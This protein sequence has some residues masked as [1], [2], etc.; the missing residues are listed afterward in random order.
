MVVINCFYIRER[1]RIFETYKDGKWY[2]NGIC[3]IHEEIA[4]GYDVFQGNIGYNR[5][6]RRLVFSAMRFPYL[7]VYKWETQGWSLEKELKGKLEYRL[8][9]NKMK[10][11]EDMNGAMEMALTKDFIVLLQR[12]E[13]LEGKPVKPEGPR[14]MSMLPRSLFI[15]DYDLKLKKILNM[16]FPIVRICGDEKE[17]TLYAIAVNDDFSMIKMIL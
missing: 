5:Q 9:E 13:Q 15:Y 12:D 6:E 4:N 16:Q 1:K 8:S 2:K 7:A 3:P 11:S 10:L 14:D 17:N